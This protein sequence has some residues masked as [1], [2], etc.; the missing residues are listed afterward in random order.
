MPHQDAYSRYLYHLGLCEEFKRM[1]EACAQD[2]R[3]YFTY[4]E[5]ESEHKARAYH[6]RAQLDQYPGQQYGAY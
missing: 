3:A 1:K 5:R 6:Y 2:P 4:G